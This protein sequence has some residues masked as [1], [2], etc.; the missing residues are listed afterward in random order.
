ML[1]LKII[2]FITINY[3]EEKIIFFG[4]YNTELKKPIDKF[5]Q[6]IISQDLNTNYIEE[7][8]RQFKDI[9]KNK[10]YEFNTNTTSYEDNLKRKYNTAIDKNNNVHIFEIDKMIHDVYSQN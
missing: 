4:G 5:I 2:N 3:N 9:E 1:S 6:L 8:D 7:V 10:I